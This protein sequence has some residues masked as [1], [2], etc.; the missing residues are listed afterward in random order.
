[1]EF[2]LRPW[3]YEDAH[4]IAQA[5]NNPKILNNLR[6]GIPYPYTKEDGLAFIS[7]TLSAPA[8]SQY[9]WAVEIEGKAAGSIG[10]FRQQNIH[11]RT[12]ELGYYI[13]EPYWGQ[14]IVSKAVKQAC[15]IVFDTTD[16]I[17]IF[18][19][20]FAHN[21]ASCRVLEKAGFLREGLLRKNAVKNGAVIDMYMYSILADER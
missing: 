17:R 9:S 4:D 12:A 14:G 1:M 2:K 16:I 13:A 3:V 8:G 7:E 21:L 20:P 6:D 5:I 15:D 19:E 11:F 18:A 10:I